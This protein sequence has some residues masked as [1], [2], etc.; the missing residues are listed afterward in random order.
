MPAD[1]ARP[2]K[3][4][5]IIRAASDLFL[6]EGF[7]GASLDQIAQLAGVSKQTIYSH[8]ADKEAL[9]AA[10]CSE[11]TNKLTVSMRQS[12]AMAAETD[13]ETLLVRLGEETLTMM[14][15]PASLDLHRLIVS[16]AGRFPDLGRAAY[17]SGVKR[18]IDDLSP[19]LRTH[20]HL[21]DKA[22]IGLS[23]ASA[24][25]L[26][27]QFMGMLRGFHQ[28]RGLLGM[29]AVPAGERT[30]YIRSCVALLLRGL[31]PEHS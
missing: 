15:H 13:L 28:L 17:E 12:T 31:E 9:F 16:A 10:I 26:T 19:V 29:P 27:E 20:S 30:A 14:L 5:A 3:H 6:S 21:R 8:F 7:D 18:M 1:K 24:R 25:R 2:G 23:E 4:D 11:L 22:S